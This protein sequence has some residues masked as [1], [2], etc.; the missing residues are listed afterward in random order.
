MISGFNP[1]PREGATASVRLQATEMNVS[2]HAP[3]KGRRGTVRHMDR[4]ARVSIHAPAKGRHFGRSVQAIEQEEFQSTPPRRGDF[5]TAGGSYCPAGF[6]PR[7]REGATRARARCRGGCLVSIH[8]PA[9]GRHSHGKH[10][11]GSP[12]FNPR[13][14][15][16]ATGFFPLRWIDPDGF[17]PRPRE[18]ATHREHHGLAGHGFQ[19]T[20]PRR[21]DASTW[22]SILTT[23]RFQ[24]TPPRRGDCRG[25]A[26]MP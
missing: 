15:E 18:G 25:S 4:S 6:N 23:S 12:G 13:P 17:N 14:R 9:K 11:V 19:S 16:G 22:S 26:W 7:P 21:G 24:S 20:P 2:I 10:T 5:A 1:R 3:A 8:A